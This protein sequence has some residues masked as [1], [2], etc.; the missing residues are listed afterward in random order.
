MSDE[1]DGTTHAE[2]AELDALRRRAYGPDADI[3]DDAAAVERLS[4]IE[5]Q[6]LIAR[7]ARATVRSVRRP[8][9]EALGAYSPLAAAAKTGEVLIPPSSDAAPPA[10]KA[11]APA[12]A[13]TVARRRSSIGTAAVVAVIGAL[14]W[15]E[16]SHR[17]VP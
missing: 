17:S 5:E 1:P 10:S 7:A 14:A 6:L 8:E 13:P 16:G 3:M 2:H 9:T 4:E 15:S 12:R 11:T